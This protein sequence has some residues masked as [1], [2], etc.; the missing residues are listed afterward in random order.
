MQ[1][2][3]NRAFILRMIL[4]IE[5]G[6]L[7][8]ATIWSALAKIDLLPM[9]TLKD[10]GL[11]A[12]GVLVGLSTSSSSLL[13]S[14]LGKRLADRI[15]FLNHFCELVENVMAPIFAQT[16][17]AD[18]LLI[19]LASGFC[20]EVMYR[21]VMQSQF[22]LIAASIIFGLCHYAGPRYL[23][24]VIWAAV[25]GALFGV[26]LMITGCL[27]VPVVAHMTSNFLSLCILRY[28]IAG[29]TE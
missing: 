26:L 7:L 17:I 27:W 2:R 9:L 29:N 10:P 23:F 18:I 21:G 3:F 22:G 24:Y 1:Q 16:T 12:V 25:V 14:W 4:L 15:A 13:L 19:S 6:C 11:L 28:K 20:E 8:V 5:A